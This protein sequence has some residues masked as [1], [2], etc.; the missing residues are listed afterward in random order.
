MDGRMRY[1]VRDRV[2][3]EPPDLVDLKGQGFSCV[4]MHL[5]TDHSDATLSVASLLSRARKEGFGVAVTDHNEISGS[6]RAFAEREQVMVV[7]G[8]EISAADGPHIL[9]YFYS[10]HDLAEFYFK[11]IKPQ[12]RKSPWLAIR[13]STPKIV[14]ASS[15]YSCLTVAAHPYGYLMFNKGLQK[16]I[17]GEYLPSSILDSFEGLEVLCG[18]MAHSLNIRA[19]ELAL[20]KGK[21]FTGGTDGHTLQDTGTVVTC[22]LASDIEEFLGAV[23]RRE[24]LV[25]GE[26]KGPFMKALTGTVLIGKHSRYFLPSMHVHFEQNLPRIPHY[27]RRKL[28]R[29]QEKGR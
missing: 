27:F 12:K 1:E 11:H 14:E 7:P 18:G 21:C 8:I 17:D 9:V 20:D 19:L 24:N 3:F 4:D 13:S 23:E 5:H 15:A 10:S 22:A 29:S 16:C 26:E 28:R 2:R 25:I 6:L